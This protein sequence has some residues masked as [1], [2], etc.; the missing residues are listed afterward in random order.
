[1]SFLQAGHWLPLP[2][3]PAEQGRSVWRYLGVH[4]TVPQ[5]WG[6]RE[7]QGLCGGQISRGFRRPGPWKEGEDILP[8]RRGSRRSERDSEPPTAPPEQRGKRGARSRGPRSGSRWGVS[9]QGRAEGHSDSFLGE[10]PVTKGAWDHHTHTHTHTH[11]HACT[12]V[13]TR[14]HTGTHV[15]TRM[16]TA[17]P[18]STQDLPCHQ[19]PQCPRNQ[20]DIGTLHHQAQPHSGKQTSSYATATP[21]PPF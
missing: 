6:M 19:R 20:T 11:T 7:G 3:V 1:M 9:A 14:P 10:P 2:A 18:P 17:D 13:C 4:D 21:R 16:H 5:V 12:H 15:H 8:V